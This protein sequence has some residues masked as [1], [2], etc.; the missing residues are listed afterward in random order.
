MLYD[1]YAKIAIGSENDDPRWAGLSS[2]FKDKQSWFLFWDTQ[3]VEN[4]AQKDLK[5]FITAVNT[6]TP[7]EKQAGIA[8]EGFRDQFGR[9]FTTIAI[10]KNNGA[11]KLTND[12]IKGLAPDL[13]GGDISGI[14]AKGIVYVTNKVMIDSSNITIREKYQIEETSGMPEL[15]VYGQVQKIYTFTGTLID[16]VDLSWREEFVALYENYMRGT[17]CVE[18]GLVVLI[19]YGNTLLRGYMLDFA[20]KD[21]AQGEGV[22]Q[23][24]FNFFVLDDI[25]IGRPDALD[26]I[27]E[28]FL[29]ETVDGEPTILYTL[30]NLIST[31]TV[32]DSATISNVPYVPDFKGALVPLAFGDQKLK[33][34]LNYPDSIAVDDLNEVITFKDDEYYTWYMK[35]GEYYQLDKYSNNAGIDGKYEFTNGAPKNGNYLAAR[36]MY[37]SDSIGVKDHDDYVKLYASTLIINKEADPN[38]E[39]NDVFSIY[40]SPDSAGNDLYDYLISHGIAL[41]DMYEGVG[42]TTEMAFNI[43]AENNTKVND[44]VEYTSIAYSLQEFMI[45]DRAKLYIHKNKTQEMFE[46]TQIGTKYISSIIPS[47][48][49]LRLKI[50]VKGKKSDIKYILPGNNKLEFSLYGKYEVDDG[51][52]SG[53]GGTGSLRSE[54]YNYMVAADGNIIDMNSIIFREIASTNNPSFFVADA[55]REAQIASSELTSVIDSINNPLNTMSIVTSPD[56]IS[57]NKDGTIN[58]SNETSIIGSPLSVDVYKVNL[59]GEKNKAVHFVPLY[60]ML[61][62]FIVNFRSG[63]E[64]A[65]KVQEN[66]QHIKD[67]VISHV[68]SG[69]LVGYM[70]L[71]ELSIYQLVYDYANSGA[72]IS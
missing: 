21:T 72:E 54:N 14:D 46:V 51:V 9:L 50:V 71:E 52:Y 69:N 62:Q 56:T 63:T 59:L 45:L 38:R 4:V 61:I 44:N 5:K 67:T 10:V 57:L 70:S 65:Q 31:E 53:I 11:E 3:V 40:A 15:S 25:Q 24:S 68:K 7:Q 26:E 37:L 12:E 41:Y 32:T 28:K 20:P 39:P 58:D 19:S 64:M 8:A 27:D 47:D 42:D 16:T 33:Y 30:D 13:P 1:I 34:G 29:P 22:T 60:N 48:S 49:H 17:K 18:K 36:R 2:N 55:T 43:V 23:F 66:Q 35:L 6:R